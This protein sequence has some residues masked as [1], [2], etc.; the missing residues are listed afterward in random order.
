M[1]DFSLVSVDHQ[2]DFG[3]ISFVPVDHDPFGADGMIEQART[4]LESQSQRLATVSDL[5]GYGGGSRGSDGGFYG[6]GL[7]GSYD[8]SGYVPGAG[9]YSS[10]SEGQVAKETPGQAASF[11][12]PD[13]GP[14]APVHEQVATGA[15]AAQYFANV[16][17]GNGGAGY[18]T[19]GDASFGAV[20]QSNIGI[21]AAGPNTI[22]S[23]SEITA[24]D[25]NTM[26]YFKPANGSASVTVSIDSAT[27][28]ISVV[29]NPGRA[30]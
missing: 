23:T 3:D 4:Q 22:T 29:Q 16:F 30:A 9:P 24:Y 14:T 2:P 5:R 26:M 1:P 10:E 25:G 12:F 17:N 21:I 8:A 6:G 18:P 11:V 27:H 19:I 28:S 7:G 15:E 20:A 13:S